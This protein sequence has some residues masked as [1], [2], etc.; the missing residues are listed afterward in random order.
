M[1]EPT[2]DYR[3]TSWEL[4]DLML[5]GSST[6]IDAAFIQIK[7]A[8]DAFA[9]EVRPLLSA[10]LSTEPSWGLCTVWKR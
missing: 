4:T 7:A 2:V 10:D 1:T 5:T 9:A 6:E 3:Q 8:I